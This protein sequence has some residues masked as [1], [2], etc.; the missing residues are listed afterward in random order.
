[1]QLCGICPEDA[2][3]ID[4]IHANDDTSDPGLTKA[5]SADELVDPNE[6]HLVHEDHEGTTYIVA[7]PDGST[8]CPKSF[9][10]AHSGWGVYYGSECPYNI[11]SKLHGNCQDTFRSELRA[12]L[13]ILRRAIDPTW[14]RSDCESAVNLIPLFWGPLLPRITLTLTSSERFT[15]L[16]DMLPLPILK[17]HGYRPICL[18]RALR[19]NLLCTMRLAGLMLT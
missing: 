17:S 6:P 19:R 12:I 10:L 18:T 1:M 7:F 14:I 2:T 13:E 4:H 3:A 9:W 16:S 15:S 8:F 5:V 11:S